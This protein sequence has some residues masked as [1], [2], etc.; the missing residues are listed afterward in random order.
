MSVWSSTATR[1]RR[2][3]ESSTATRGDGESR[4]RPREPRPHRSRSSRD[5]SIA[6]TIAPAARSETIG[7]LTRRG[8]GRRRAFREI[9]G[10]GPRRPRARGTLLDPARPRPRGHRSAELVEAAI[11]LLEPEP[12][13]RRASLAARRRAS[14]PRVI[15]P[16]RASPKTRSRARVGRPL[17]SRS[18][19]LYHEG[20]TTRHFCLHKRSFRIALPIETTSKA[21]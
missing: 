7:R 4:P 2:C 11:A 17:Q 14:R 16:A 19:P 1:A 20:S 5:A 12:I 15:S 9:P 8:R 13:G 6:R 10:R 21:P 3:G 18:L